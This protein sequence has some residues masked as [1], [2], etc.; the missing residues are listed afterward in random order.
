MSAILQPTRGGRL[1]AELASSP[2][3]VLESQ[4]LRYRIFAGE[5]G[6]NLKNRSPGTDED[7]FD[8]HCEH[9]LVRDAATG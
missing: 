4:R 8:R 9:L 5:L 3:D 6:A 7:D 1:Y 2:D